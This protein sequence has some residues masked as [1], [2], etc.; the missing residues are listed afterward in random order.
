LISSS[1]CRR[2][3]ALLVSS[4]MMSGSPPE[5]YL[6]GYGEATGRPA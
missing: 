2:T 3:S 6:K 4:D 5:V 1:N